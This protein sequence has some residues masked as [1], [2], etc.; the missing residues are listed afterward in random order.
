MSCAHSTFVRAAEIG[1]PHQA[2]AA[3]PAALLSV[4]EVGIGAVANGGEARRGEAGD[5]LADFL[6]RLHFPGWKVGVI[7][8]DGQARHATE[9]AAIWFYLATAGEVEICVIARPIV[10]CGTI[11]KRSPARPSGEIHGRDRCVLIGESRCR[12]APDES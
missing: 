11:G 9:P 6:S 5:P 1:G 7:E 10:A 2:R 4:H 3:E 12:T 8:V